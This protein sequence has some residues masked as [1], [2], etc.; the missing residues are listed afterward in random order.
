MRDKKK[1]KVTK[2]WFLL[3]ADKEMLEIEELIPV[4]NDHLLQLEKN[5][6]SFTRSEA[7]AIG[8]LAHL[9][10][11]AVLAFGSYTDELLFGPS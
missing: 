8:M 2:G 10:K 1:K 6:K 11:Q 4:I 3:Q 9:A 7:V 5:T